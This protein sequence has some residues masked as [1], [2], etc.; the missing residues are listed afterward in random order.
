M[1]GSAAALRGFTDARD[2]PIVHAGSSYL[3]YQKI[4]SHQQDGF[5]GE[6]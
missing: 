3:F 2:R 5:Y 4:A 6:R 1:E